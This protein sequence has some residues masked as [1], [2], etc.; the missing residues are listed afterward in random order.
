MKRLVPEFSAVADG[1]WFKVY[2]KKGPLATRYRLHQHFTYWCRR[3][4]DKTYD[5]FIG[6]HYGP[7]VYGLT[8][9]QVKESLVSFRVNGR[10]SVATPGQQREIDQALD[11][12]LS[13]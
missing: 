3:R 11:W 5:V 6:T 8:E 1:A 12:Y 13:K 2:V 10:V 4:A 9:A 7:Y